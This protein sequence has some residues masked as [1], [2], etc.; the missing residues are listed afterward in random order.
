M[1][2]SVPS[3]HFAAA[4]VSLWLSPALSADNEPVRIEVPSVK[5]QNIDDAVVETV[6]EDLHRPWAFEFIGPDE[7]LINEL[8]GR[9]LRVRTDS[10]ER[11]VLS[12]LPDI[13][14]NSHQIGLLDVA[15]H[16]RFEDNRRIYFSYAAADGTGNNYALVLDSATLAAD[17]L[18]ERKNVL[19]AEPY[20]WSPSN[21]GG[22]ITF[23]DQGYLYLSVGDRSEQVVAQMGQLPQ[24]KILRVKD[25]GSTPG[26]NPFVENPDFDNRIYALGVRNP[27][28][29]AF[30]AERGLLLESEHGP[31]GG[32]EINIIQAGANYGWPVI[33]YGRSYTAD[34]FGEPGGE[35]HWL[36][37]FH[38]ATDPELDIGTEVRKEGMEQPLFYYL[39]ST[40]I[41]PLAVVR[42]DM[43]PQWAGDILVGALKG[44][45]V[46][47]LDF[48]GRQVRSEVRMLQEL[49][50]RVRD[51]K[52]GP[53]G[54]IW[55]LTQNGKLHRL[56][57]DASLR[58][59]VPKAQ[60]P[61]KAVYDMVCASCHAAGHGGAPKTGDVG[62]WRD[63]R[64]KPVEEL[65]RNTLQGI[66]T[67]PER[68]A[69]YRC[70][71]KVLRQA[72]DYMLQQ[73]EKD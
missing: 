28:G 51:L 1:R 20:S 71:D 57:R 68:G 24:G 30:D 11:T 43:F 23:D 21:F 62:T 69:C 41:S 5:V 25:D 64:E 66:G 34:Q 52:I 61:G 67:M 45:H 63:L 37:Q 7:V 38:L 46:S 27:Q 55:I 16:P 35:A 10:G 40:A 33:S 32:D 58:S 29:L 22:A 2:A 73:I 56:Y 70:S 54:S 53:D 19:I 18:E 36:L 60:E 4:L 26:D 65:Y 49:A 9:M 15:L 13:P 17:R 42:G 48:D 59:E 8:G 39:P 3:F 6:V 47:R 50:S 72:V 31:M 14:T 44:K 12:G